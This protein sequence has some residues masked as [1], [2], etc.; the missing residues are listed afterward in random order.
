MLTKR[1]WLQHF[2]FL[3]QTQFQLNVIICFR[4]NQNIKV[5]Q[6]GELVYTEFLGSK[7][8]PLESAALF[9]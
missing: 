1:T 4:L 5:V 3:K 9:S 7:M 8:A 6:I 2:W